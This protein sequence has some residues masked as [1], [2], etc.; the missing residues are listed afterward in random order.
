MHLLAGVCLLVS[1]QVPAPVPQADPRRAPVE[2]LGDNLFRIGNIRVDTKK[3][4][5]T[6]TGTLNTVTV[7]EFVA[8]SRGGL[9]AYES[10]ITLDTDAINF[11][12][13]LVLI[14]LDRRN[15]SPSKG[16]FDPAPVSGDPVAITVEWKGANGRESGPIERILHNKETKS[17]IPPSDWVYTGSTFYPDGRFAAE[18]DGVLI[19]FAHT[20]SSVIESVTGIG[21]GKYGAIVMNPTILQG[22]PITVRITALDKS[23]ARDKR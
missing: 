12:I 23:T 10:A 19:G 4:E 18:A 8:N 20:P 6:L 1:L 17:D 3:R 21:L 11:N 16:H 14:G 9:K 5:V 15:A 2:R 22:Q 7:L 13:A